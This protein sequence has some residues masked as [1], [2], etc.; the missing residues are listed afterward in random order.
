[1]A[2]NSGSLTKLKVEFDCS[3]AIKGLKAIQRE[4]KEATRAIKELE[5]NT[6]VIAH[7]ETGHGDIE[8]KYTDKSGIPRIVR[9]SGNLDIQLCKR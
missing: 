3:E 4:A 2:E 5:G 8:I 7:I 9:Y 6:E 1:M